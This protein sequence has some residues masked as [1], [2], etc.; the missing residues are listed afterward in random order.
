MCESTSRGEGVL[1]LTRQFIIQCWRSVLFFRNYDLKTLVLPVNFLNNFILWFNVTHLN[2]LPMFM[3]L[4]KCSIQAWFWWGLLFCDSLYC[5]NMESANKYF[6]CINNLHVLFITL[7][8]TFL[9]FWWQVLTFEK[10]TDESMNMGRVIYH[11]NLLF[12]CR[13]D[14]SLCFSIRT[15]KSPNFEFFPFCILFILLTNY[16][17]MFLLIEVN[18]NLPCIPKSIVKFI[19]QMVILILLFLH[20][21]VCF[22]G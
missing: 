18:R 11:F 17:V 15:L 14:F 6:L 21:V 20:V 5:S 10:C 9:D 19:F 16:L 1:E 3:C 13:F 8:F 2:L 7:I 4:R 12:L 22:L